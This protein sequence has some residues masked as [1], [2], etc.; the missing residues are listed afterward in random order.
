MS[1]ELRSQP[2]FRSSNLYGDP[3]TV[4]SVYGYDAETH[5]EEEIAKYLARR[6]E[7]RSK[8]G[9]TKEINDKFL[10]WFLGDAAAKKSASTA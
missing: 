3:H 6:E 7:H 4:L 10:N 1:R 2:F 5:A 8:E 9:I